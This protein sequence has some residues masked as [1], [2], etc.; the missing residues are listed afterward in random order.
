MSG[1]SLGN[2]LRRPETGALVGFV[3]VILFYVFIGGVDIV[4]LAK[5]ASWVNFAA[6][7]GIVALPVCL[8]MI[9]G[10]LDISFGAM[11]PA[12]S[13]IVAIVT[14][15]YEQPIIVGMVCCLA[16][17]ALV[18]W[19]N[20]QL[21][22]RTSVPSLIITLG[23]LMAVQGVV[24]AGSMLLTGGASVP[25]EAPDWAKFLFGQLIAGKYQVII[26]WWIG[27]TVLFALFLHVSPWGNWVFAL[28]GDQTSARN[29]GIPTDRLKI[30]LFMMS[31]TAAAFVG[32]CSAIVFN[33]AQVSGGMDYIF[34][35]IVTVVI[36]GVLLTGGFG[37]IIGVA[38]RAVTFAIVIRGLDFARID[39]NWADLIIGVVL[40]AAVLL[41]NV[42]RKM[43]LSHAPRKGAK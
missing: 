20:G 23:S 17:G 37:S 15:H 3:T 5:A 10:E 2:L 34:N 19:F 21:V 43:A 4:K 41:N 26:F 30:A 14:G 9:A 8:L 16:F 36:G 13:M 27:L 28:G 40:V 42:F 31:S 7:L 38:L 22:T 35:V 29:A 18:G 39:K 24:L 11:I 12:G 6:N 1:F 25:L 32:M 33:S